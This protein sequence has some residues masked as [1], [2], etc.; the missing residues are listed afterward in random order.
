MLLLI[1]LSTF[2]VLATVALFGWA[3]LVLWFTGRTKTRK[4]NR[5]VP[6]LMSFFQP[7]AGKT[8]IHVPMPMATY[9]HSEL[10]PLTRESQ[11]KP[12]IPT[13]NAVPK[14]ADETADEATELDDPAFA[15][16]A[17]P[18]SY[19]GQPTPTPPPTTLVENVSP[20]RFPF[21][22]DRLLLSRLLS[23]DSLCEQF[24]EARAITLDRQRE[25]GRTYASLF[26]EAI[27]DKPADVQ[28]VLLHLLT[29]EETDDFD[30]SLPPYV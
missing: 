14:A 21:S 12:C 1:S 29:E 26:R 16:S 11:A 17:S 19:V 30:R 7:T 9:R 23:D 22:F 6:T 20:T 5:P 27:A 24:E 13:N 10:T 28:D 25:T 8:S 18:F 4:T 3:G 15:P 2:I